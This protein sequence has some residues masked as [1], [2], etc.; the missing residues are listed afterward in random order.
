MTA[1]L[2]IAGETAVVSWF[3]LPIGRWMAEALEEAS[4][5][6]TVTSRWG[7]G[8]GRGPM[9]AEAQREGARPDPT[10]HAEI[11]AM[12]QARWRWGPGGWI[13]VL[14]LPRLCAPGR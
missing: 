1:L 9:L 6:P 13:P 11:L 3:Y 2:W 4:P 5:P 7:G 10:A 14:Q 8:G 12:Q